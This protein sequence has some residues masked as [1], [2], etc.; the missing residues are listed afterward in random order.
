[1][2]VTFLGT[3]TSQG[4]PI[5]GCECEV[6][7]SENKKDK[8][9]RSSVMLSWPDFNLVI[10]TGPDFRYQLLREN[11]KDIDA[12]LYTHEH[13]DHIAGLDD[14]RPINFLQKKAIDVYA[15]DRVEEALK[16]EFYYIF[17]DLKYPGI[18]Q[19][20]LN[21]FD[22]QVFSI[23]G[24]EIIPIQGLHYKLPVFGFRIENFCYITD[25]NFISTEEKLKMHN[26]DVLVIN[27]L[28]KEEHIS[29][30]T[31]DQALE[32]ISEL[33]PKKAFITHISHQLGLHE[34]V[35][36]ELPENVFLA[37]DQLKL[38]L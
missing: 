2:K 21:S 23:G 28:R 5:I 3:G 25:M 13:K 36:K 11:V 26:L 31:L 22:N 18:P 14:I 16:R 35:S 38:E 32:V 9:L 24:H 27:G 20:N 37:Y 17:A 4:V 7:S 1:M 19:I 8:R 15:S 6:C 10:D 34:N 30:F 12:V 33:K 29:H